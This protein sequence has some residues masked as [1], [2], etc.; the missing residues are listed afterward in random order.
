MTFDELGKELTYTPNWEMYTYDAKSVLDMLY[1]LKKEYAKPV[2]MS[3]EQYTIF[4]L[5]LDNDNFIHF[6]NAIEDDDEN[7]YYVFKGINY[8]DLMRAWLHPELIKVVEGE[9]D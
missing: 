3:E 8:E 5:Y 6:V 7:E 4:S 1:E 9:E 2:E